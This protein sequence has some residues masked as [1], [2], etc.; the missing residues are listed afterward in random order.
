MPGV[1]L[2][3]LIGWRGAA[4]A[5]LCAAA[6]GSGCAGSAGR[7]RS[8]PKRPRRRPQGC[9]A[10]AA[11]ASARRGTPGPVHVAPSV[12]RGSRHYAGR[13][14]LCLDRSPQRAGQIVWPSL[15]APTGAQLFQASD[16]REESP[17]NTAPPSSHSPGHAPP[18]P[19]PP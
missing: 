17:R 5:T 7:R 4:A 10:A 14:D 8:E 6:V 19:P 13:G 12:W 3:F 9:V 18:P 1:R 15:G 16:L 2:C 11:P